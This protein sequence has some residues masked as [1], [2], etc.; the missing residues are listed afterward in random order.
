MAVELKIL[1]L[2]A[3]LLFVYIFTATGATFADSAVVHG[4]D[5]PLWVGVDA[6]SGEAHVE[7]R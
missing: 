7:P 3:L 5:H 6:W 1:A 2:G 4:G